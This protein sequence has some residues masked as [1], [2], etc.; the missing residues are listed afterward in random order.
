MPVGTMTGCF[1]NFLISQNAD[2][3][4][5]HLIGFSMGAHIVG[6][7]GALTNGIIPRI[8]G[9]SLQ[10]IPNLIELYIDILY[11]KVWTLPFLDSTILIVRMYWRK[12]M[13]GLLI[14]F[15]PMLV[16]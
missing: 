10:I 3:S 2:L 9:S 11:L 13:L 6:R 12:R 16:I 15:T 1:V 4:K 14:L 8:T 7:A 5:I